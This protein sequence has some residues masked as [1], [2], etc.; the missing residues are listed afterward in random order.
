[1]RLGERRSS[2]DGL[3]FYYKMNVTGN[4]VALFRA[5]L[6]IENRLQASYCISVIY[7]FKALAHLRVIRARKF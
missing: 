6:H 5:C 3:S 1:M 4:S 2:K 7:I